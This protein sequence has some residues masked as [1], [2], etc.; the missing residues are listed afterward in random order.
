L[1]MFD[2]VFFIDVLA[3]F[4]VVVA[5]SWSK[6]NIILYLFS[7]MFVHLALLFTSP[8]SSGLFSLLFLV[9]LYTYYYY[10]YYYYYC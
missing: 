2:D 5:S 1:T 6:L 3:G 8:S 9:S 4:P 7:H 10:H